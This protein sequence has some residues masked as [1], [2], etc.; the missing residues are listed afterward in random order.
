DYGAPLCSCEAS[1]CSKPSDH[2]SSAVRSKHTIRSLVLALVATPALA[3]ELPVDCNHLMAWLTGNASH[4]SLIK[5]LRSRGNAVGLS[6]ATES[7][8]RR[9]GASSEL[10]AAI[11][12]LPNV[13]G[14]HA[15][16]S[17]SLAKAATFA[18]RK[19]YEDAEDLL[20]R[21]IADDK[22]NG[23]L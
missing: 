17:A 9:A 15:P 19:Q 22:D 20:S 16:C 7:E 8:L 4:A 2:W 11:H 21:V 10:L 12:Q 18:H 3:A 13:P 6:P 1:K 23:S 5:I 14:P